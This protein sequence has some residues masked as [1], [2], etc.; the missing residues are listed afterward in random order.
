MLQ[1]KDIMAKWI[2]KHFYYLQKTPLRSAGIHRLKRN[3]WKKLLHINV[4]QKKIRVTIFLSYKI[5]FKVK[6]I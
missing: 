1:S 4:F 5:D 2:Q 3:G 6:K